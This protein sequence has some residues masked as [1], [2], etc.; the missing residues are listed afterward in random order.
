MIKF[1][2]L[3]R[4]EWERIFK[5]LI[6]LMIFVFV[7]QLGTVIYSAF[8]YKEYA[9]TNSLRQGM[10]PKEI[11]NMFGEFAS[12]H[13]MHNSLFLLPIGIGVAAIFF[14]IF[15]IWYRDWFGKNTFIYRLLML[16]ISRMHV[17]FAKLTTILLAVLSLVMVQY[18][19]LYVYR[20]AIQLIIPA[21]YRGH[22]APIEMVQTSSLMTTLP[23]DWLLFI[24]AYA[25]G[26]LCVMVLFTFV[27]LERSYK[28]VG[29]VIGALY[30]GF[31]LFVTIG[32]FIIQI[33]LFG[34]PFF[35]PGELVLFYGGMWI[36]LV[37]IT[38]YWNRKLMKKKITV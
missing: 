36:V 18:L 31:V 4:F 10:S 11:V 8:D 25:I 20:I 9:I 23:P 3:L 32:S 17:Y 15:F 28:L 26:V 35:Y 24:F 37:G 21:M 1:I 33:T 19:F 38:F 12:H 34:E 5:F 27:L 6:G 2:R 14:Y 13:F 29:I 7:V 16:P 30:I 22:L